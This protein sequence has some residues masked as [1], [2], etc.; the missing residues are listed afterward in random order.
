MAGEI[1]LKTGEESGHLCQK[2]D[3]P[4]IIDKRGGTWTI[5]CP[6]C[7]RELPSK[8]INFSEDAE[9]HV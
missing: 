7:G 5:Y 8:K 3:T 6:C 2:C 1:Y 4:T 9:V